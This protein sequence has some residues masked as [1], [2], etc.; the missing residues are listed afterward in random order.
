[1]VVVEFLVQDGKR[2]FAAIEY[3]AVEKLVKH[4][5]TAPRA[6]TAIAS[7]RLIDLSKPAPAYELPRLSSFDGHVQLGP[8][9]LVLILSTERSQKV[10]FPLGSSTYNSLVGSLN[11]SLTYYQKRSPRH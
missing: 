7:A 5:P 11:A 4:R 1:M 10:L 6:P 3:S 8:D 2:I 9:H